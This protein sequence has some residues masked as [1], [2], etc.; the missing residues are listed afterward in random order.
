MSNVIFSQEECEYIKS[1]WNG[2]VASIGKEY[3]NTTLNGKELKIRRNVKAHYQDICDSE[4]LSFILPKFESLGIRGISLGCVKITKYIEDDYFAPHRDFQIYD[5][6]VSK[7]TMVI[8][9]S[10]S[11]DY[12]G[13][14]LIVSGVPQTREIGEYSIFDCN[15]IHEVTKMVDGVRYSLVIFLLE[16]DFIYES[17]II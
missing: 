1:F 12:V 13:G 9:L 8:Q 4:L 11:S 14:D 2:G 5:M 3:G 6:G 7:K 10:E 15:E 17:K 16:P